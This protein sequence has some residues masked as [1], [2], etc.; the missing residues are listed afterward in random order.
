MFCPVHQV[1]RGETVEENLLFVEIGIGGEDPI[2]VV[3]YNPLRI[4]IPSINNGV[5]REFI[6]VCNRV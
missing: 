5:G 3:I 2:L 6:S 4:S 1:R